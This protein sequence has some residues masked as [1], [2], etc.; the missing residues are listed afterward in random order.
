MTNREL[1]KRSL[2]RTRVR[3]LI[4]NWRRMQA[5]DPE[6]PYLATMQQIRR[7]ALILYERVNLSAARPAG[8]CGLT[9]AFNLQWPR[10][11]AV[12]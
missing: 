4:A 12:E 10:A 2:Q 1:A 9:T 11:R 5:I 8:A 7:S 6:W 3:A